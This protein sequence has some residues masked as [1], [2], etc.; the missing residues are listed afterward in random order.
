LAPLREIVYFFTALLAWALLDRPFGAQE[1]ALNP[2][3]PGA[4]QFTLPLTP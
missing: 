2:L 1:A 3:Q 4:K